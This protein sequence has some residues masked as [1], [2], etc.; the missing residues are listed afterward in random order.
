MFVAAGEVDAE[1][2]LFLI[3]LAYC[4]PRLSEGLA[5]SADD[6]RLP[7]AFGFIG[8]TKNG[9]PRPV[10]LPPI[11]V[12]ELANHPRGLDR[13]GERLFRFSKNGYL[14]GL[15]KETRAKA[16]LGRKFAFHTFRHTWATWMRR[17][18]GLDIKGLVDT[19]A[20]KD[21][22]SAARY[23]HVVISEE[24]KRSDLLPVAIRGKTVES[25]K[26]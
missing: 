22:K 12:A 2:R 5:I 21:A 18:A 19:G 24:A 15:L 14:Y 7:E 23:A 4:G 25:G 17:Y 10:H 1:F 16:K 6:I 11:V 9:D 20:W 26:S 13:P 8:T 3:V